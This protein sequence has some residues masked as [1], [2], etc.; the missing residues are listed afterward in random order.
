MRIQINICKDY[1]AFD[2]TIIL[3]N[4]KTDL[5]KIGLT[6]AVLTHAAKYFAEKGNSLFQQQLEAKTLSVIKIDT[7]KAEYFGL[8]QARKAGNTL[9]KY[10]NGLKVKEASFY[11][12]THSDKLTTA[13]AEGL[14]LSNYEF[15]KYKSKEARGK[16]LAKLNID[17]RNADKN[18]LD[19][20][21]KTAEAVFFS[22]T[23]INE[24]LSYLTAT[25]LSKDIAA[26]GKKYGFKVDIY[27]KKKIESLKMGGL[28]AVNRGSIDPPTFTILEYK[29][30]KAK[31]KKPVVLVG[32]GVVYDTGGLSLKPTPNSMD[33]MKSDMSGAAAVAGIFIAAAQ[34][35]LPVHI[36][37]LIPATDNRP[38]M[39]AYV[40]G[41]VIKM[42]SGLNV[43]MLNADAEGRMILADALHFAKKYKPELVFDFATLT[44]AA[45]RAIGSLATACMGTADEAVMKKIDVSANNT[46]ERLIHFPL[47]DEYGDWIKSELADINNVGPGE[48]G[49]ITAGKF[50][51]H[52]TDYPWVHFDIAPTAFV[53]KEDS[54][55]GKYGTGIMVR[56]V[57]DFLK[58]Y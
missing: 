51:Q 33:Q 50:L 20:M 27:N 21:S 28:L 3:I 24:P 40:P 30:P 32:K 53:M 52:F 1:T 14:V 15:L 11:N 2:N 54:Y 45:V 23:L 46:Y 13:F 19:A 57:T 18:A 7:S 37:G 55:R 12:A 49:H 6:S 17:Q 26:A 16:S 10:L 5:K 8:E 44:G 43:E 38:G 47:W 36:V 25:Q 56:M 58:N 4:E 29:S 31:N 48:A 41:D 42:M 35:K 9:N 39:N 34:Q 22:R